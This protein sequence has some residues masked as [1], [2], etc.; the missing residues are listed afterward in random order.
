[1]KFFN[2]KG[3]SGPNIFA[4]LI[5][6]TG[7]DSSMRF[8]A[9]LVIINVMIIWSIVCVRTAAL[10]DIPQGVLWLIAIMILGKVSQ[11]IAERGDEPDAEG[12]HKDG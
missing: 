11:R 9:L 1:M 2:F 5:S 10:A 3:P 12:E 6:T 8:M 4:R 7:T